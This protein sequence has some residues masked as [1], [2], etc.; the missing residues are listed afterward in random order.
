[1]A[2]VPEPEVM[3]NVVRP[4]LEFWRIDLD[5][6]T[7][8]ATRKMVMVRFDDASAVETFA[9][10]S[11]DDVDVAAGGQFLQL[12][13]DGCQGNMAA[14]TLDQRVEVLGT[15]EALDL[16]QHPNYL[17][18]LDGVSRSCH[19]RS[20]MPGYL[21]S[22]IILSSILGMILKKTF[23]A[24]G[25]VVL[26][27]NG[28]ALSSSASTKPLIVS[29]V[30]QWGA[31]AHQLVGSDANV[32][33]LLSD[34]NADPHEHEA[35]ISDAANVARAS[36]VL[37]NGAG[38]DAWLEQLVS[39]RSSK[40]S[41]VNVGQ[42]MKVSA[43]QNPHLFYN[44]HAAIAFVR[45]L[46]SLLKHRRGF[47]NIESRSK[48]LI[49]Q[50]SMTQSTVAAIARSC[51]DVKVAATEDVTSY[52]L[53]DA[54]LRIVTPEGLRLAVG[55]GVDPS[56]KDL[57]KA[58]DQLKKHPAFLIDNIQTATPLTNELAAQ[59]TSSHVPIIKVTETMRGTD[60][61]GFLNGV[62]AKI[63]VVLRKQGCLA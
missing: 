24:S 36:V 23:L 44:P 25:L 18:A 56:I 58:L 31:L 55:N 38:Y 62:I 9:A 12:R 10:V 57:A 63:Q 53:E 33:S 22:V 28:V 26:L 51:A 2:K 6:G 14:V 5:G 42:L 17:S 32:V 1:M 46:T 8:L 29:G 61:V 4:L 3:P 48:K 11:H 39:S 41:V 21:L 59:A 47:A 40:V 20:L 19:V 7:A 49:G 13:V 15:H 16:A 43:G 34:P 35:T 30:S 50:L 45:S 27:V 52:L 54:R 60:Y 37:E